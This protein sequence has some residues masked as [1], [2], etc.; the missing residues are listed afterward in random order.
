MAG[1]IAFLMLTW[2]AGWLLPEHQRSKLR[3]REDEF[4][5]WVLTTPPIRLTGAAAIEDQ[6][7]DQ[8][9]P[10]HASDQERVVT[11]LQG[12]EGRQH[13]RDR[14]QHRD[15]DAVGAPERTGCAIT[16]LTTSPG[17]AAVMGLGSSIALRGLGA[18]AGPPSTSGISRPGRGKVTIDDVRLAV[19]VPVGEEM[20]CSEC[21]GA[22]RVPAGTSL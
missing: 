2:R 13:C 22:G 20:P 12:D 19:V 17:R 11:P 7:D 16:C 8:E 6:F 4:I 14:H 9:K 5:E 21:E 3:Q 15:G 1:V 18:F 10:V